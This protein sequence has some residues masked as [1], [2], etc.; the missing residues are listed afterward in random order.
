MDRI[1]ELTVFLAIAEVGSLAGAARQTRR[2]PPAV[3]RILN[4]LEG[5][6]GVRLAERTTRRL[7][8]TDAGERLAE[9]AR[10][11]TGEFE[12]AMRDVAGEAAAARGR[13][14]ISAPLSFGRMHIMP[15]VTAFLDAEPQVTAELSLDDRTVDLIE[16]GIDVALR[17]AE[18][19]ESSL[20]ARRI[21][22]VRRLV[23]ASPRYLANRSAPRRPTDLTRHDIVLFAND[24]NGPLWQFG[25]QEV[26]VAA[27]F[28]TNRA[29]A[30]IA[31]AR[32]GKG[33][34]RALSYQVAPGLADGS[35]VR[36][37]RDYEPPPIPVQLVYPSGRFM[38][39]RL[40]AFLDFAVPRLSR[41]RAL[42]VT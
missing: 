40:R 19:R 7:A 24:V 13:L 21:G 5:R 41:L 39:A 29:E 4:E 10:R 2:S 16:E 32:D 3:T 37:L 20:V 8:L 33:I 26:R 6:L 27:R 34:A 9:H 25:E 28:Q 35:L 18:L 14:R 11:L 22:A 12:E 42:R 23:V 36:L 15:V 38:S 1:D 30:A 31:A 17:I